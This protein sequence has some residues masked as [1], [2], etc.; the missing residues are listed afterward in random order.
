MTDL[1]EIGVVCGLEGI[2]ATLE[3]AKQTDLS[4]YFVVPSHVPFSPNMETSGGQFDASIIARALDREDAVGLSEIVAPYV[5]MG[6]PDL[7]EAME[8]TRLQN[9]SL[10]GHLPEASGPALDTCLALGVNTDHEC[11][12][13]EEALERIRKG[14]HVMMREGSA[15]RNMPDLIK[16]L[17]EHHLDSTLC[18]IVTDDLHT[19]MWWTGGI[20][21]I[22]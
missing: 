7:L 21:M 16:I 3:E 22:L 14:C 12:H 13:A 4:L 9:K 20:L 11:L 8:L 19:S 6:Y 5:V 2:E 18:S 1:H 17:T 10:Q 15:A